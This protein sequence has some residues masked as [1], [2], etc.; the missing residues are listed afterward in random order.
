M[1]DLRPVLE[2][3]RT[4][5]EQEKAQY[6]GGGKQQPVT[7]GKGNA[8]QSHSRAAQGQD[9]ERDTP[10]IMVRE[11]G[12]DQGPHDAAGDHQAADDPGLRAGETPGCDDIL[13][14]GGHR[15]ENPQTD[16]EDDQQQDEVALAEHLL[17]A[18][19]DQRAY[20]HSGRTGRRGRALPGKDEKDQRRDHGGDP[21]GQEHAGDM[22]MQR[23]VG[24]QDQGQEDPDVHRQGAEAGGGGPF[25]DREPAG[26]HRGHRVQDERLPDGDPDLGDEHQRVI[27]GRQPAHQP[28]HSG[29]G[30]ADPHPD[31]QAVGVDHPRSRDRDDD[32]DDHEDH[33]QQADT[34]VRD[35]VERDRIGR[36]RGKGDPEQLGDRHGEHEDQQHDPA[37]SVDLE[38]IIFH[39]TPVKMG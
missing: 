38:G 12:D 21:V 10:A 22:Q 31:A 1:G 18:V 3:D 9:D 34:Q 37:V 5:A 32:I 13:D 23:H 36:D 26:C 27:G 28:E 14:P 30:R 6:K 20:F 24:G 2:A 17:E 35:L 7:A 19:K 15:I 4:R 11:A 16:K 39:G 33:R 8:H 25:P 29:Q